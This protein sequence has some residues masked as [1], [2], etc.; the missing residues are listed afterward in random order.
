MMRIFNQQPVQPRT[1]WNGKIREL[2]RENKAL[3]GW[4]CLI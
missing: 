1:E 3:E 2:E 4:V